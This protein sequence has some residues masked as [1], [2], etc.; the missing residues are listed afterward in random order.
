MFRVPRRG[1]NFIQKPINNTAEHPLGKTLRGG[2][3]W[4][5]PAKMDR[6][7]VI[8]LDNLEFRVIHANPLSSQTRLAKNNQA[9]PGRNHLLHVMQVEPS[10]HQRLAESIWVRF[11]E[12]GLKDFLPSAKTAQR[13]LG[14]LAAETNRNVAFLTRKLRE[15]CAIFVA[16]RKMSEQ[17][18]HRLNLETPQCEDFRAWDPTQL[19]ERLRDFDAS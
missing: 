6:Y 12:R 17:I 8:I 10:A 18:F 13:S 5:N 4:G 7:F 3:D 11:F 2:I 15:L 16:P 9:L 19:L 14:H 1:R